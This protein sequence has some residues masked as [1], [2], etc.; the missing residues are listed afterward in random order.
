MFGQLARG[1]GTAMDRRMAWLRDVD[2]RFLAALT[3]GNNG[4]MPPPERTLGPA[5]CRWIERNC[6]LAEGDM[7][8]KA[9]QLAPF[10]RALLWK[11]GEIRADGSRRYN[12]LLLSLGKGSGKSPIGGW[13]GSIDLAGPSVVCTGCKK[14]DGGWLPDGA[15]HAVRRTSPDVLNMASSYEQADLILD[16]IRVTFSEGPL[17]PFAKAQKGLVELKNARGKARRIPA[18]VRRA[19][20][21]KATTLLVDEAHELVSE[22]Q[23]N[24]YD[25]ASGG[26]AKR[27][28]GLVALLST[29]GQDLDSMFGRE[30]SRGLRGDF[31]DDELF[32]YLQADE[33]LDPTKDAD[34]AKGILQ[35][36]PLAAAG[37]ANVRR[38]VNKFKKMPLFRAKRYFWNQWVPVDESWLPYGAW[39]GC[40]GEVVLDPSLPTWV[41]A[42]MAKNRDSAAVVILQRR[43]D[44]RLQAS[45]RIWFPN[46]SLINQEECDDYIRMIGAVYNLQWIAADEAWWATLSSLEA[47]DPDKGID[48][49]PI[50][51]MPQQGRN[52][53]LAYTQTYRAIVDKILVHE[54]APDFSDQIASAAPHSTDRG[55]TLKKGKTKRRIDSCPALAGAIFAST[56]PAPEKPKPK[57]KFGVI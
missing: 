19:D 16:E 45:S 46:G 4:P 39:D 36:N 47:G 9:P 49:L 21:S 43:E 29:A 20:G 6:R 3:G 44:G 27:E 30:V 15:P 52:M 24:A 5:W 54:G 33:G 35:A 1:A 26:T 17:A 10:Q 41:G 31:A 14:C 11:L 40:K 57:P 51:R 25:V 34:I 48:P 32:L 22:K 7:Y 42:D 18:T 23:E 50:F 55:W 28:D 2:P 8:G 37:I 56:Q 12:F 53:I 38:L 13:L